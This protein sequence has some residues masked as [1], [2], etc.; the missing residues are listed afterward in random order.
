[1]KGAWGISDFIEIL[2]EAKLKNKDKKWD[3]FY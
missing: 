1:M 3:I 2:N